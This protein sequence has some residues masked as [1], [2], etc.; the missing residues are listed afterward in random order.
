MILIPISILNV[1]GQMLIFDLLLLKAVLWDTKLAT[2]PFISS[3][4]A[5]LDSLFDVHLGL[6]SACFERF[7]CQI[8]E[9]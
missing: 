3:L 2:M 9:L 6:F 8:F 1:F 7:V 4:F 5:L